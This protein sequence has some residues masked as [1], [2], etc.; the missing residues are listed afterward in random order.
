MKRKA[1]IYIIS[2]IAVITFIQCESKKPQ[3]TKEFL[4]GN[5]CY[6][7]SIC[8]TDD[9]YSRYN[10]SEIH[11]NDS[12]YIHCPVSLGIGPS[13]YSCKIE[14]DSIKFK[15]GRA[16]FVE[17]INSNRIQIT[18]ICN[19]GELLFQE[20]DRMKEHDFPLKDFC[21]SDEVNMYWENVETRQSEYFLKKGLI[22]N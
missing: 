7:D 11:M 1:I 18:F 20:L 4:K 17:V 14:D 10:Y 9:E 22:N 15:I 3:L 8:T 13:Y 21:N 16:L 6:I 2:I 5:W 19:G 12:M